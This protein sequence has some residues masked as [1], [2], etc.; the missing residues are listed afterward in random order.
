MYELYNGINKT[1]DDEGCNKIPSF[2]LVMGEAI[3][4]SKHKMIGMYDVINKTCEFE[5]C[6]KRP[7]YGFKKCKRTHCVKHK[8]IGMSTV[9]KKI[10]CVNFKVVINDHLLDSKLVNTHIVQNIK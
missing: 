10:K 9:K 5:G 8:M 7:S 6:D 2:G 3:Y 4:C 1:C